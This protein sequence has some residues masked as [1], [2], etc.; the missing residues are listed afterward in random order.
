MI[1]AGIFVDFAHGSAPKYE[2]V[3]FVVRCS[4]GARPLPGSGAERVLVPGGVHSGDT[5]DG[6][7]AGAQPGD[8]A[9]PLA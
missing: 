8:D 1:A 7:V 5:E 3:A 4:Q 2:T 9:V 6:P